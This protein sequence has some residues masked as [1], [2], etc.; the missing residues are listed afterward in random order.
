M[1]KLINRA[2]LYGML[3]LLGGVFYR[4][5][6]KWNG[7]EGR[8]ALSFVHPHLL[9]LGSLLLLL[10]ALFS[11]HLPLMESKRFRTFLTLHTI[12]LPFM[13]IMMLVRGVVQVMG[14]EVTRGLDGAISGL[15]GLSHIVLAVALVYMFLALKSGVDIKASQQ[16]A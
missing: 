3:A 4:E 15:A 11:L 14:T 2:F 1:K 6:T 5:F 9:M 13:V 10:M 16:E 7:F 8:T 12:A